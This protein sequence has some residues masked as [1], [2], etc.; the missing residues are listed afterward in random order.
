[1]PLS[2]VAGGQGEEPSSPA[3]GSLLGGGPPVIPD[4]SAIYEAYFDFVWRSLRRLGVPEATL[5]DAAQDVFV[6]VHRRL[7][8]FEARSTVKTWLFGIVVRVVATHRRAAARRPTEPLDD[9]PAAP[10][11]A[12][13]ELTEAREAAHLVRKLL[14]ELT[15][16]RR[17]VFVL[18]ELEQMSAPEISAALGVNLNTVYSR[19]RA[20]RHD[21]ETALTRHRLSR[22]PGSRP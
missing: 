14:E 5:D 15:D 11:S 18:T 1:M 3:A 10:G 12:P 20:A 22:P 2:V 21:F 4:F 8:E 6:V 16:D 13:E 9:A 17:A 7:P 19:L